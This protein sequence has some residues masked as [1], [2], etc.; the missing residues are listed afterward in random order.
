MSKQ[1]RPFRLT[2]ALWMC[3]AA[4]APAFSQEEKKAAAQ[5]AENAALAPPAASEVD[6]TPE[7]PAAQFAAKLT[8]WKDLLKQLRAVRTE[9]DEADEAQVPAIMERWNELVA[10]GETLIGELR[11]V[12]AQAY[13]AAPNEDRELTRFLTKVLEDDI[14]RDRYEQA[15]ELSQALLDNGCDVNEVFS[16][17]GVAAFCTNNFDKAEQYFQEAQNRGALSDDALKYVGLVDDYKEFW[18]AEQAI[19][20]KEA[21]ADDLPRVKITTNKGEMVVE[22]FENE[23]PGTVGNFISLVEKGY[24]DGLTFHRVLPGF[25]AQGGCPTGTGTGGPGY[26]IFCECHQDNYRKHFRGTL[27]MAHAGRDTGG[28]QFFITFVPTAHLNGQHTAFA[29]VIEGLDVLSKIQ[30]IDPEAK[31]KPAPDQIIKM[32]V[33]RKRDHEYQPNKVE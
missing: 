7:S 5:P 9:Y 18:A 23:A 28:S 10:Q 29:R 13:A 3:V 4:A 30:R 22:L 6:S 15:A 8:A 16:W 19:R 32:E 14:K 21:A 11:V 26:N 1:F 31:D 25:M 2:M 27:S 24:Y 20:A 17:G 33:L 12:G